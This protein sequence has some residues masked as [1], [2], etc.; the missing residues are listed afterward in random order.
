MKIKEIE[1][2]NSNRSRS[3]GWGYSFT[4]SGNGSEIEIPSK[5]TYTGT[6][7]QILE[8]IATD[9]VLQ[10]SQSLYKSDAWFYKGRR[11]VATWGWGFI[12]MGPD[13][14]ENPNRYYEEAEAGEA[15]FEG[16]D[17]DA[18]G[19]SVLKIRVLAEE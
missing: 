6:I 13:D 9:R 17:R 1:I 2:K 16:F 14:D 7:K 10:S 3:F 8:A 4:P 11:I 5:P 18:V 12:K 19:K 15:F